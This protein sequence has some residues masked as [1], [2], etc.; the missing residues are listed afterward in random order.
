MLNEYETFS[1]TIVY[2]NFVSYNE[3]LSKSGLD[4]FDCSR[5]KVETF[6]EKL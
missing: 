6:S 3:E 4:C 5:W 1:K 2:I